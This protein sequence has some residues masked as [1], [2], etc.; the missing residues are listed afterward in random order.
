MSDF[1]CPKCDVV[2]HIEATAEC[3]D[4]WDHHELPFRERMFAMVGKVFKLAD[5]APDLWSEEGV[6][7]NFP[8]GT[9]V[10]L[11]DYTPNRP[12]FKSGNYWTIQTLDNK[13]SATLVYQDDLKELNAAEKLALENPFDE[14]AQV[15][16]LR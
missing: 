5:H 11:T 8:P 7:H 9:F 3:H 14:S 10:R 12:G 1:Y 6:R 4:Y 13:Y 2:G 15:E 16:H